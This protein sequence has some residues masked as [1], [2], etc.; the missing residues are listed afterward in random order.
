MRCHS[1]LAPLALLVALAI[2]SLDAL[3]AQP[4]PHG[5]P[6]LPGL[7]GVPGLALLGLPA[8]CEG[9]HLHT[10]GQIC[11]HIAPFGHLSVKIWI[12]LFSR[13]ETP[14]DSYGRFASRWLHSDTLLSRS[15]SSHFRTQ[16]HIPKAIADLL[17]DGF[18]WMRVHRA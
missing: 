6:G 5:L 1:L 8:I 15:G 16:I 18:I 11:F 10:C 7:P 3:A 13:P 4:A 9:S 14:S 17:P 12:K 2:P